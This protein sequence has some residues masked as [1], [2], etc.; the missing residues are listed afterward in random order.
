MTDISPVSSET[1][2][3]TIWRKS[4]RNSGVMIGG[5]ILAI[6]I[7]IAILPR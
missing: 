2:P 7:L 1:Q 6:I 4:L 5:T 3:A